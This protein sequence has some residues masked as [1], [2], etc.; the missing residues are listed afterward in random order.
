M[1]SEPAEGRPGE[2]ASSTRGTLAYLDPTIDRSIAPWSETDPER[3]PKPIAQRGGCGQSGP[4][5]PRLPLLVRRSVAPR[6]LDSAFVVAAALAVALC[7][8]LRH[9]GPR[10]VASH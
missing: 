9:T 5:Q 2:P 3:R 10:R 6:A 1:E 7:A 8:G 4:G